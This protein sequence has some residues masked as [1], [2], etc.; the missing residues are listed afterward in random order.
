MSDT[1]AV[2]RAN[3]AFYRAFA[4]G[5]FASM[6]ALW[7]ATAPVGCIHPG[8]NPLS[9]RARVMESWRM[10]LTG[11]STAI[12]C[13]D[14]QLYLH[15]VLAWVTCV[16]SLETN[17]LAATNI[18]TREA[19]GWKMV[20]HHASPVAQAVWPETVR[21]QTVRPGGPTGLVH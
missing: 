2:L 1:E 13:R 7:S 18:F 21:P 15:G 10:I 5:D 14:P 11:E 8:W 12:E 16:E 17:M 3:E 20:H 9:D 4:A 6:E 19:M